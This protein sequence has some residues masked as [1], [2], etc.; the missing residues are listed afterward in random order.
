MGLLSQGLIALGL[1][2]AGIVR[3]LTDLLV[4][5]PAWA[6][7]EVLEDADI[8]TTGVTISDEKIVK[9]KSLWENSGAVIMAEASELS[10]L[11]LQLDKLGVPLY[12]VVKENIKTEIQDFKAF[13]AGDVFVDVTKTFYG[14]VLRHMGFWGLLRI[15]V[16]RNCHRAYRKCFS[17]NLKG[18]GFIL[19]GVY[20]I[21]PEKQGIL[22]EHREKE[23]GDRVNLLAV[24]QTARK[25]KETV[26]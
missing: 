26:K 17:G 9:G 4:K 19:G 3:A 22:L 13:F 16:W 8:R 12:A 25:I 15:G 21:G 24:L 18:E 10:S 1:F 7:L 2:L 5:K 14:P 20:V 23:F 6:R 11:K